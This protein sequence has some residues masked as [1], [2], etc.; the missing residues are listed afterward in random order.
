MK[1]ARGKVKEDDKYTCPIC[2][3]R[4]KIPRDAARPKLEDLQEWQ[5]EIPQLPFQA[6]EEECLNRIV[7]TAQAFRDFVRPYIS[8]FLTTPEE[9]PTQRFWLRKIEGADILLAD[10]TNFFRAELHRWAPVA[11]EPPPMLEQSLST[12]KPRPTKQQKLMAQLGIDNPDDLPQDLRTKTH[13]FNRRKSSDPKHGSSQPP[14]S[15]GGISGNHTS[16]FGG[17]GSHPPILPAPPTSVE[18][19]STFA[20]DAGSP[21]AHL[22]GSEYM[23]TARSMIGSS[24]SPPPTLAP[25]ASSSALP[26]APHESPFRHHARARSEYDPNPTLLNG[27][28]YSRDSNHHHGAMRASL[29][30]GGGR[31]SPGAAPYGVGAAEDM[32]DDDG[33]GGDGGNVDS[34]FADLTNHDDAVVDGMGSPPPPQPSPPSHR[35]AEREDEEGEQRGHSMHHNRNGSKQEDA[36]GPASSVALAAAALAVSEATT[37][38]HH[39]EQQKQQQDHE[40]HGQVHEHHHHQRYHQHHN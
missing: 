29:S 30:I 14:L 25:A 31:G 36:N 5:A 1:I 26:L 32:H 2:D 27:S 17:F 13:N 9:L 3:W 10:E 23:S 15:A 8:S 34:I 12:R 4:I 33:Q 39:H 37:N 38:N 7:R 22:P 24:T 28:H 11:P 19:R 20:Y 6:D 35:G 40:R 18:P 16:G 21:S